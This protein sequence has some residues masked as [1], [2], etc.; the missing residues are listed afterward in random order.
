MREEHAGPLTIVRPPLIVG[1][2]DNGRIA[3]FSGPYTI[4]HALASGLAAVVVGDPDGYAEISPVDEVAEAVAA[5][6][7][8]A[9]PPTPRVE[10]IAGGGGSL[11]LA[12][13]IGIAC[14]TLNEF[15]ALHGVAG[16]GQPSFVPPGTWNRFFLPLADQ[17]L[18]PF[19]HQAVR[20]WAARKPRLALARP[21]PWTLV[22][23]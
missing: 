6:V 12:E 10:V 5:A 9:P 23:V 21:H 22:G 7:L 2:R 13:M 3:R 11:R 17:Y 1:R 8:A 15:R 14:R 4:I 20:H 16:I 18:S 19:Q